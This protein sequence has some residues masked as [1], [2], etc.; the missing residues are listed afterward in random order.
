MGRAESKSPTGLQ[1]PGFSWQDGGLRTTSKVAAKACAAYSCWF[2][3]LLSYF[4]SSERN[5]L[6]LARAQIHESTDEH[7]DVLGWTWM[8]LD[9][10]WMGM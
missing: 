8:D 1:L 6:L 10:A 2:E 4:I 5:R 3:G 7:L 9:G